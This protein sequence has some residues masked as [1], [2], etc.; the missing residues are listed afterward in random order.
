MT[1]DLREKHVVVTGGTGA[2][3]QEVV[4]ALVACNASVHVPSRR[5]VT[6][7]RFPLLSHPLVRVDPTVDLLQEDSVERFY[8]SLPP[9][10]GAVNV[11]GGF[12][13]APIAE[14]TLEDF[15][16]LMA[17]N[18]DVCFLSSR[19]AIRAIRKTGQGGRIV[20][21]GA[22]IDLE[23]V[24]GMAAYS[25]SK[26]V[27]SSLTR[28]LALEV[29]ADGITVNA[30]LPGTM[31]TPANRAAMPGADPT[32]WTPLSDVAAVVVAFLD[33]NDTVET[34]QLRRID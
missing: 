20:H 33:T 14:T 34:G 24:A 16:G 19:E 10:W 32:D 13:M 27:V 28:T 12:G 26:A 18:A 25:A 22:R 31:D 5:P 17:R 7:D 11:A 8:A 1:I 4:R 9:L 30:V 29:A 2:L 3:G 21:V 6:V 15:R 23:P